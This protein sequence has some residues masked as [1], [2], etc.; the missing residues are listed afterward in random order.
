M[1]SVSKRKNSYTVRVYVNGKQEKI[2]GFSN[3]R[4]AERVGDKIESLIA[5]SKTG[6]MPPELK[7]WTA[8]LMESSPKL[9]ERL[10]SW[11][12]VEPLPTK[13]TLSELFATHLAHQ[14][15]I[16]DGTRMTYEKP[17]QNLVEFFGEDCEL[18][19]ITFSSANEFS[20]WLRTA[21]LNRRKKGEA[22]P[23][24]TATVNR[25]IGQVKQFFHFA[26]RLQW[27]AENPFQFVQ[28]GE[29]VNPERWA[30]V[31]TA[32]METVI[33]AC[34]L[35]K[36]RT[37]FALGRF[38]GVRGASELYG[39]TWEDV[40]WSSID[41]PGQVVIKAEKN[42]RHGRKFRTV[43]LHPIA[44]RELS[45][46]FSQSPEK[47]PRVFPGMK[48]NT[49]VSTMT[50]KQVVRAGIPLWDNTWYNLRKSFCCDLM[51]SGIDPA[52]YEAITDHSYAVAMKHYQIPHTARLQK[53]YERILAHW[54]ETGSE[55]PK[56][57][58]SETNAKHQR[59][60]A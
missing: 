2:Y 36:W 40:H 32:T 60:E 25:R 5:A 4:E 42:K 12:L 46:L 27:I 8:K 39:L 13:H 57:S 17:Q 49:N 58:D 34:A 33:D 55:L 24:S 41:E 43:P 19:S 44:E 23:Y 28:G 16:T 1:A 35:P 38:A 10:A 3:K 6:D 9:Y 11:S 20:Q 21:P 47:E 29:S 22:T 14:S 30:Y 51:A 26:K 54:K 59:L 48:H 53:G 15:N 7:V 37:I 50:Q 31:D 56:K 45:T 52:V 18:D